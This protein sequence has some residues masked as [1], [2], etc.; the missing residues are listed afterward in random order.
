MQRPVG[1]ALVLAV[2]GVLALPRHIHAAPRLELLGVTTTPHVQSSVLRYRRAPDT[3]LGARVQ[4]FLRN[5]GPEPLSLTAAL[6]IR[7]RDRT[8]DELLAAGAWA[9]HDLPA[10]WPGNELRLPPGALTVWTFNSRSNDWGV[11]TT[12]EIRIAWPDTPEPERLH[13]ALTPPDLWLSAV[14]FPG[15][16]T[17]PVPDRLI[18]HVANRSPASAKLRRARLWLPES[19]AT[20]RALRP[21]PWRELRAFPADGVIAAGDRGGAWLETGPLPLG[22]TAVE[23]EGEAAGR[24]RPL[25]AHLRIKREAF[26]FSGGWVASEVGGRNALH[27][28]PYLK[29]LRR[30]HINAGQIEPVPGY[31]DDPARY[32]LAPL[33]YLHRLQPFERYDTDEM[34]PRIHAVEFLGE[35]QYGGG[36]PVPPMEVWRALAPYQATRLPTSLTHSEERVWRYY[37]GLSDYP[38]YDAYRVCAPAADAWDRYERWDGQRIRWGAPLETIGELTRSLRELNRPAPIAYWSQGAHEGWSPMGGRRRTSPT[39]AELRSQAYHALAS[40]ITSLYWFNLS[41]KSLVKF[42]D[43][44]APITEVNRHTRLLDALYL[45]GDAYH[46]E[47]RRRDGRPDWDLAVIAGPR[48]AVLFALDLDYRPDPGQRVFVFGPPRAAGFVFP[49]PAY[50]RQP[51]EVFRVDVD[52]LAG[53][54]HRAT[55]RGVEI[56]DRVSEVAVYVAAVQPGLRAALEKRL[57]ELIAAEE[58]VDFD[59]ARNDADWAAL[60]A[61]LKPAGA[62]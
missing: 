57:R 43:L 27:C 11:G 53:V 30:M 34:L 24:P 45:E 56:S 18:F 49:L 22:Y 54:S 1:P 15:P 13:F 61:L 62:K 16:E 8:P 51:A 14:T 44:I 3:N 46:H 38:H 35:P 6:P 36:R 7:L 2:L 29:T 31:S 58:A 55:E 21:G 59:P 9:W 10:A 23:I 5:A 28:E 32:S 20:W 33:K 26:D 42:R 37:A 52:G 40:R 19:N 47:S 39:P 60:E 50:L 48:A 4:L 12:A 25:W 41:V 17:N